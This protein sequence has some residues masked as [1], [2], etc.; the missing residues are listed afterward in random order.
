MGDYIFAAVGLVI[1]ERIG[2]NLEIILYKF[3][4]VEPRAGLHRFVVGENIRGLPLGKAIHKGLSV[5]KYLVHL[6]VSEQL[7]IDLI[8]GRSCLEPLTE[9][10]QRTQEEEN[11]ECKFFHMCLM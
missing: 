2:W 9:G 5:G 11:D 8:G 10:K 6:Y 4:Q 1:I 3:F 7:S